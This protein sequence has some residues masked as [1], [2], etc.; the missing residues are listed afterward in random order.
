MLKKDCNTGENEKTEIK[1][2]EVKKCDKRSSSSRKKKL[3]R[4]RQEGKRMKEEV[5][6]GERSKVKTGVKHGN[7]DD[8][9]EMNDLPVAEKQRWCCFGW[10]TKLQKFVFLTEP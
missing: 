7:K 5:N 8:V 10:E 9:E 3:N 6:E 1:R 2:S 4:Q